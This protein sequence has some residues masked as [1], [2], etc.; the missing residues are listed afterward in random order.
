MP[1]I[2]DLTSQRFGKLTVIKYAGR[3]KCGNQFKI[4][5][6]CKCDC[7]NEKEIPSSDLRNGHSTSCGCLHR[8]MIG[9]LNR[10]HNL[11]NKCGRIYQVW[12]SIK[13]RCNNPN[14]KSFKNYGGRGIK[15]CDEWQNNFLLFYN[16]AIDNGY[17]EEKLSNGL[18]RLTID[19][20][21]NDGNYEPNN[22]RWV[23]NLENARN[24]KRRTK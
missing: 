11:A 4:L 9:D 16:W 5:W 7:G 21:D 24:K 17:K 15:V 10:K 20:I 12:K 22:C 18:N 1:N 19:R 2:I 3:R 13:Y 8:K 23:T 6:L 14:N